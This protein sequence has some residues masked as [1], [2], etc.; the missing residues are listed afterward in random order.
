MIFL[1]FDPFFRIMS[2]QG[3][4]GGGDRLF[5]F[6]FPAGFFLACDWIGF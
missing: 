3:K 6:P 1:D 5:P 4:R 2:L